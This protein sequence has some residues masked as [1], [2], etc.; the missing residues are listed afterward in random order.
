MTA[1]SPATPTPAL[2]RSRPRWGTQTG[3]VRP[4]LPA[5]WLYA[6]LLGIGGLIGLLIQLAAL[7]ASPGAWVLSWM[8]LALYIV[9]VV[10]VVRWLDLYE[11]EP[12]SLMIGAFLWGALVATAFSALANDLWG[13]AVVRLTGAEFASRWAAAL[14]APP[15]EETYKF[16]GLVV[17]YLISRAQFADLMDGFV[18]GAMVGLG[19]AVVEDVIYFIFEFGGSIPAVLAGFYVRVIASGLYTHVLFTGIAGIGLAYFVTR[20]EERPFWRR[21]LVAGALLLLAMVAHFVWNSPWFL[22]LPLLLATAFKGLPFLL[23]LALL[24]RLARRREH[25]ALRVA[26]ETEVGRPGLLA[27]ELEWLRDPGRRRSAARRV[28]RAAGPAAAELTKELQRAQITLAL[29][30][31]RADSADH[32]DLVRQRLLCHSLRR[33]LWRLPGVAAALGVPTERVTE[34]LSAGPPAPGPANAVVG[35]FGGWS[36]ATASAADP[37]R[38]ALPPGMPLQVVEQRDSWL[39]VRAGTG[40]LGWTDA[41][42]LVPLAPPPAA[43]PPIG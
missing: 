42:Y 19:F 31:S 37:Q 15:V 1:A 39:L 24:L 5:F 13:T 21:L 4:H 41:S 7:A 26:L 30:S 3:L 2:A 20:R 23:A 18:Y 32:A 35:P 28:S 36:W 25:D 12:P 11:Q 14:I 8:L 40:W 43:T 27:E 29:M 9:P 10:L 33:T 6:I 34:V 22:E 38:T 16:L 17:L